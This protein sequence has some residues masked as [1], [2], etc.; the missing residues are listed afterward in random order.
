[1]P[2]VL[3]F[4]QD[5][6]PVVVLG[7]P[8]SGTTFLTVAMNHHPQILLTNELRPWTF[9]N[10]IRVRSEPASE[11]LPEHPHRSRFQ[12]A[13][14]R[15][16]YDFVDRFYRSEIDREEYLSGNL[17][18][19]SVDG[20]IRAYGDKN[21]SYA[22]PNEPMCAETIAE[23]WPGVRF[24]HIHRDPRSCIAS[25]KAVKVY[26]DQIERGTA[27]WIRH[28]NNVRHLSNR[29]GPERLMHIRYEDFVSEAGVT[30]FRQLEDFLD[31]D[32]ADEPVRFLQREMKSRTPYR[33][34]TTP[35]RLLGTTSFDLRLTPD[36]IGY[37]EKECRELMEAFG[38]T[39][40]IPD[41]V[42]ITGA[43]KTT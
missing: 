30:I 27:M 31:L 25:Y 40:S 15:N 3:E 2:E 29:L 26:S 32:H 14:M 36:D 4:H 22:D 18:R 34:P 7:A 37:I 8:R 10:H 28:L 43:A 23:F 16:L 9:I 1:M 38:Y 6:R 21:P 11:L 33:A 39:Q 12:K 5:A 20:A 42:P 35:E 41:N 13:L 24:V 17:S 19:A